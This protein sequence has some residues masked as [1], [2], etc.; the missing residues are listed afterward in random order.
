M[1]LTPQKVVCILVLAFLVTLGVC[2]AIDYQLEFASPPANVAAVEGKA[3]SLNGKH[4]EII[5]CL[6]GVTPNGTYDAYWGDDGTRGGTIMFYLRGRVLTT[7][8]V[9]EKGAE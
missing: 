6:W 8:N 5:G 1:R 2:A 3:V 7:C 4:Y 9:R